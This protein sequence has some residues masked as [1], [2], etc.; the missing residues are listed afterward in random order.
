MPLEQYLF[1]LLP[2]SFRLSL[3]QLLSCP[4]AVILQRAALFVGQTRHSLA[5]DLIEQSVGLGVEVFVI[6]LGIM[7]LQRRPRLE[8]ARR[9]RH[10][11]PQF[12]QPRQPSE[13]PTEVP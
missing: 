10:E 8:P 4:A 1:I 2:S 7:D 3:P 12:V 6:A 9:R 5:I 13:I 11:P